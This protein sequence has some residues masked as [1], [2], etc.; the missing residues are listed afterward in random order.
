MSAVSV[1]PELY[2]MSNK[3]IITE[4]A[5]ACLYVCVFF[6]SCILRDPRLFATAVLAG[7]FSSLSSSRKQGMREKIHRLMLTH[8]KK[9]G[10]QTENSKSNGAVSI[11]Q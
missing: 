6:M 3:I 11:I 9:K 8:S 1:Y 5:K 4:R 2:D 7:P 10:F